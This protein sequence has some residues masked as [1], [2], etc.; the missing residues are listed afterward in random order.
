MSREP[1]RIGL[2]GKCAYND[3]VVYIIDPNLLRSCRVGR[4]EK[5]KT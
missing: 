5:Q 1:D 4:L 2:L 3:V